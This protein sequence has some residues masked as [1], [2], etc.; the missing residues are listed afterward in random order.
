MYRKTPTMKRSQLN[1]IIIKEIKRLRKLQ[2]M[3]EVQQPD[4]NDKLQAIEP[5]TKTTSTTSTSCTVAAFKFN[6]SCAQTHL[7]TGGQPSWDPWLGKRWTGYK[8]IGCKH[9]DKA[10]KWISDQLNNASDMS[11][12]MVKRKNE[13]IDWLKCV[14]TKCCKDGS[15]PPTVGP[16]VAKK[17]P[18]VSKPVSKPKAKS[19]TKSKTD[20]KSKDNDKDDK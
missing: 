9:L 14:K 12:V 8:A 17:K 10:I 11:N 6:S 13:K 16:S 20:T 7:K 1:N 5:K 15:T 3:Y 18:T 4:S 19:D 2:F